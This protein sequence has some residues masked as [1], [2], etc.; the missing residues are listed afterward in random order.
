MNSQH[1]LGPSGAALAQ[2]AHLHGLSLGSCLLSVCP[3]SRSP[4]LRA[5]LPRFL[6]TH[7]A[8]RPCPSPVIVM[9]TNGAENDRDQSSTRLV[10]LQATI[11][12]GCAPHGGPG[13]TLRPSY[14]WSPLSNRCCR[15]NSPTEDTLVTVFRRHRE[16]PPPTFVRS[17]HIDTIWQPR[18]AVSAFRVRP[19]L[20]TAA[21]GRSLGGPHSP[22]PLCH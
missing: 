21:A 9:A 14:Q 7:S 16:A 3:A 15:G 10:L 13:A 22:I 19:P 2:T 1:S 8:Y 18:H 12:F 20:T 11:A 17:L 5:D 4:P 6:E